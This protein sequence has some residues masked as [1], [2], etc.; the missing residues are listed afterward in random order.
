MKH[1]CVHAEVRCGSVPRLRRGDF[2]RP[3]ANGAFTLIELLVVVAIITLLISILL[4]SL[5]QARQ[6]AQMV[7]CGSN[8]HQM[9]VAAFAYG[10]SNRGMLPP[11]S[12]LTSSPNLYM[13][14]RTPSLLF[15]KQNMAD[16]L[17]VLYCPSFLAQNSVGASGY[18]TSDAYGNNNRDP[19]YWVHVN[20]TWGS[21]NELVTSY[22]TMMSA[23]LNP[24]VSSKYTKDSRNLQV[25]R[26]T[27]KANMPIFADNQL[28][29]D[30]Q[31]W[32]DWTRSHWG[33]S[34]VMPIGTN[35][36]YLNGSV[37]WRSMAETNLM[38]SYSLGNRDLFW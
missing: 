6:S 13:W 8:L 14:K 4:P 21:S 38:Y 31:T 1:E 24:A 18:P 11:L 23:H 10:S 7:A 35:V 25:T 19:Q 29:R 9:S 36:A 34:D 27:D 5:T 22:F 2:S 26:Q 28:R 16:G 3:A 37:L 33:T 12:D 17:N 30:A 32:S 20:E 15:M